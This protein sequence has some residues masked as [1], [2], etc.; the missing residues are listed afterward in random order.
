MGFE[1]FEDKWLSPLACLPVL[2][3]QQEHELPELPFT[4]TTCFHIIRINTWRV[5]IS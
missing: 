2:E 5:K 1:A 3:R 4:M